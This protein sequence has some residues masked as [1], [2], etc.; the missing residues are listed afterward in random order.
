MV[1]DKKVVFHDYE[2]Y[3]AY[4]L[5]GKFIWLDVLIFVYPT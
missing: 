3:I 2:K 4:G 1:S 5:M